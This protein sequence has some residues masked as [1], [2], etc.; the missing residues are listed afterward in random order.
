MNKKGRLIRAE[1][2]L[3]SLGLAIFLGA[4]AWANRNSAD[5]FHANALLIISGFVAVSASLFTWNAI[6]YALALRSK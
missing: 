5:Y 4:D 1:M 6:Q 3:A 2:A